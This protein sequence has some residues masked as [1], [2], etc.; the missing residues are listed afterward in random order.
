MLVNNY[1]PIFLN[2]FKYIKKIVNTDKFVGE[3]LQTCLGGLSSLTQA[4]YFKWCGEIVR[5]TY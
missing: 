1:R 4:S 3:I 2:A 5:K